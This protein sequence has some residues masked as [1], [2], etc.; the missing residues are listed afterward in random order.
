MKKKILMSVE[1]GIRAIEMLRQDEAVEFLEEAANRI[2]ECFQQGNKI[3]IAGNGGSM[4]DAMHFAE[5]LTGYFRNKRKALPAI[6]LSDSGHITCV[7]NDKGYDHI[8]E[9]SIEALGQKG[10]IFISLTTSG[11]S[12]NIYYGIKKAQE[13]EL[14]TIT[15]LGKSGGKIKNMSDLEWI[16]GGFATSDRVQ[17][18]H[19]TGIHILIEMIEHILFPQEE[20]CSCGATCKM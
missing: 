9:R 4:C 1:E 13:M 20:L 5:E 8:F 3:L 14:T 7:S 10:D 17:E 15:F 19:M 18:A 11:N 6:A 12:P 16:V 2:A